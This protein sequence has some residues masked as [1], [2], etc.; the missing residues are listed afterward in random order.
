MPLKD[1]A[2]STAAFG[3]LRTLGGLVG[4]AVGQ[5]IYSSV[6]T[7]K[8]FGSLCYLVISLESTKGDISY[9]H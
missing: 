3:F 2:T 8:H 4:I 9:R 1:M 5:A 7:I 6:R